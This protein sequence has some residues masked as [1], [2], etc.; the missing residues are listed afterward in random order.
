MDEQ[1]RLPPL[2]FLLLLPV[3]KVLVEKLQELW[4]VHVRYIPRARAHPVAI[5]CP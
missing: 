2:F 5:Q 4:H 1:P 3:L